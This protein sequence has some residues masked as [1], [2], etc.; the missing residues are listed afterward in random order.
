MVTPRQL[1]EAV[2]EAVLSV[3][4]VQDN[5][6]TGVQAA[7]AAIEAVRSAAK[8]ARGAIWSIYGNVSDELRGLYK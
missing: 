3:R 2:Q 8:E 1:A 5:G 7:E 4:E 6:T